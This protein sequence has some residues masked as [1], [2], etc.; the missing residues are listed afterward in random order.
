MADYVPADALVYVEINSIW[1]IANAIQNSDAWKAALPAIGLANH[2]DNSSRLLAS[3]VG[4]GPIQAVLAS[5]AQ[6]ALVIVGVSSSEKDDQLRVKPEVALVVET[7][8]AKWRMKSAVRDDIRRLAEFAYSASVC[9]ERSNGVDYVECTESKG[10][11][12]IIGAID[13]TVV[14]IGNSEK[15][16]ENCLAVRQGQR[17]SLHTDPE[18]LR[19]RQSLRSAS[20]LSFGYVSQTNAAKLVSLAGPLLIGKAPGN[21]QLERVLGDSASKILR[22]VAW[23]SGSHAGLIEDHYQISLDSEVIKRLEPVF[24]HSNVSEDFWQLIPNSFLS[25]TIYGTANPQAAWSS[26]NSA[27][28]IKLDAVSSVIF[29]ALMKSGLSGYG[30]D[31][32]YNLIGALGTPVITLRPTLGEGS[33]LLAPVKD[34]VALRHELSNALLRGGKGQ[35]L[36]NTQSEPVREKEFTA[37]FVNGFVILGKTENVLVYLAQLKNNERITPERLAR[38]RTVRNES[39]VTTYTNDRNSLLGAIAALSR[40][41]GRTLTENE[42]TALTDRFSNVE[43]SYTESTLNSSGIDRR[44][45]SAFGQFGSLI[46]FAQADSANTATR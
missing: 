33:L 40:F 6:M 22:G 29:S 35:I 9:T 11:R 34:E 36:N 21:E 45:L 23:T 24:Q 37:L 42:L 2:S 10:D 14:I 3:R 44:T 12:K 39:A 18:M 26:L 38:L 16:V 5:R 41:G 31:D 13:G 27:V 1:D 15:A 4:L 17:P 30:I 32:P 46:S 25:V 28:A 8:T 20:T 19:L 43:V 7:H